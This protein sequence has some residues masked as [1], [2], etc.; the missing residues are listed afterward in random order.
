MALPKRIAPPAQIRKHALAQLHAGPSHI[1]VFENGSDADPAL[2]YLARH[3]HQFGTQHVQSRG[4][5]TALL[6]Q[7][8]TNGLNTTNIQGLIDLSARRSEEELVP[9]ALRLG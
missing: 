9:S 8:D 2:G 4:R 7:A 5:A 6:F 3:S 1:V